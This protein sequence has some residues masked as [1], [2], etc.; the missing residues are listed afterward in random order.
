MPSYFLTYPPKDGIQRLG[1]QSGSGLDFD[2]VKLDEK[3]D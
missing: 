1:A 3:S 2:L